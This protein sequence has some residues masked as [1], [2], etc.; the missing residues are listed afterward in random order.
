MTRTV[1]RRAGIPTVGL[2]VAVM[3][4]LLAGCSAGDPVSEP[5]TATS[6][7]APAGSTTH[8]TPTTTTTAPV[9]TTTVGGE[10]TEWMIQ[11]AAAAMPADWEL[12]MTI[13]YGETPETLGTAPGGENLMLGPEY[14]A[15][16]PD[17]TWWFLDAAKQ[18][19]AHF[20]DN[21]SFIDEVVLSSE[22][23]ASGVYF[24][25]QIPRVLADGTLVASRFGGESTQFLTV[26]EGVP[27]LS[28]VPLAIF[29]KTD[30]G[31]LV[32][33]L[34]DA[35]ALFAIDA[36]AGVV[37]PTDYF[38]TQAGNR[39]RITLGAGELTVELPDVGAT[40][41]VPL[42]SPLGP[43]EVHALIEAATGADGSLHLYLLALSESD[44]TV[45]LAGYTS[46][47]ASGE[48][49]PMEPSI[50]PFT[51]ADPGSPAHLGVAYGSSTPWIMIVGE[52]G[53]DV[54]TRTTGS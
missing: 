43:G 25:Y 54:W 37:Q 38:V 20:D 39:Y 1:H 49:S 40:H 17:G 33:G 35:G 50:D 42:V 8:P 9:T 53:V 15:Q 10:V 46:I 2:A 4:A 24:Q 7:T 32:Y 52:S 29:Q 14:G 44:E 26:K 28:T 45:Q 51:P 21:G 3:A 41:V 27:H 13:P 16:G 22:F 6:T 5:P 30:D 36:G 23:L 47:S 48:L 31:S 19:L 11:P 12:H 34:D 18:R